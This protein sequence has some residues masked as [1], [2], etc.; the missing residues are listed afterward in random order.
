MNVL[1]KEMRTEAEAKVREY[2][3]EGN[4]VSDKSPTF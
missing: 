2:R 1:D 3:D 4:Y